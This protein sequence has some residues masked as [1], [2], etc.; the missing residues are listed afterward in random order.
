MNTEI[1]N[2]V[3]QII[4]DKGKSFEQAIPILQAIQNKLNY[5]PKEAMEYVCEKT[6]ISPSQIYG[7]STFYSQFRHQPVGKHIV[8]VCVGTACHVK[9]AMRV[10][11]AFKREL[12]IDETHETDQEGTFTMEKV[13]C[14]GC[15]TIAPVIQIDDITYGNVDTEKV[16]EILE[17]FLTAKDNPEKEKSDYIKEYKISEGEVRI[18]L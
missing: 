6:E 11:D 10:Y 17:D 5:L 16:T 18:G 14:L 1:T 8:K 15:C 3:D 13:S 4:D 12:D 9:G 2:I 7:I